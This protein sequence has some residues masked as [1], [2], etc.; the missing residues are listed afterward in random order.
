MPTTPNR[1]WTY[2]SFEQNPYFETIEDFFLAQ[3]TDMHATLTGVRT[4]A[5]GGTGANTFTSGAVLLGNGT[6]AIQAGTRP[7]YRVVVLSDSSSVA[8]TTAWTTFSKSIT[9]PAGAMNV[10][11]ALLQVLVEI[12]G[13]SNIAA[14]GSITM[15]IQLGGARV[16]YNSNSLSAS[17]AAY[18]AAMT[19]ALQTRTTGASGTVMAGAGFLGVGLL[20]GQTRA[21]SD[22]NAGPQ[23]L[24]LTAALPLIVNV[25]FDVADVNVSATLKMLTAEVNYPNATVS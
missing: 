6:G 21:N 16:G 9:L 10:P 8:N 24:D 3:D 17:A 22:F 5:T 12:Y 23:T 4:V 7:P 25:L 13:V 11:G 19:A 15:D 1:G 20:A 18:S 14:P 2:P